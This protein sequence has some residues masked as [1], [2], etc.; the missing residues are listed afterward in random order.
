MAITNVDYH[1]SDQY[2]E[3]GSPA[4]KQ[5]PETGHTPIQNLSV[6]ELG[7]RKPMLDKKSR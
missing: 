7:G 2:I 5:G 6:V 4:K 3:A 1:P